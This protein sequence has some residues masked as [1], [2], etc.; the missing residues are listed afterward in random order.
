M[1][2]VTCP[3][4]PL[5][6]GISSL[7]LSSISLLS[8]PQ[9]WTGQSGGTQSSPSGFLSAALTSLLNG[10]SSGR[11]AV[12]PRALSSALPDKS[13]LLCKSAIRVEIRKNGELNTSEKC[14]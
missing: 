6:L 11:D 8:I 2:V 13:L 10:N 1:R 14:C 4:P 5:F 7:F 12:N 9:E 3:Q